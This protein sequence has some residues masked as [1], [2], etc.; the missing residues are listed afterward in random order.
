MRQLIFLVTLMVLLAAC[1][2]YQYIIACNRT[3][4]PLKNHSVTNTS[5]SFVSYKIVTPFKTDSIPPNINPSLCQKP[6]CQ[7]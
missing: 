7:F 2:A 6:L 5:V 1:T 4:A 3:D